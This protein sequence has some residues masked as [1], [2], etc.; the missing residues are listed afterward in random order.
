MNKEYRYILDKSSKKHLCPECGKKRFVKFLDTEI[1]EYLPDVYGRCDKGDG[2]YFL[3]P[4]TDGYAKNIQEQKNGIQTDWKPQRPTI[5]RRPKLITVFIPVEVLKQTLSGYDKN[6]FIQNLL[7][8]VPFPFQVQDIESVISLY[9]LGTIKNSYRSGAVTFPFIDI[10]NNI[11]TIQV[12]QFDKTNHTTGTDFL[13]SIIEKHH[14]RKSKPLPQW[15]TAY[16]NNEIKVSCLFGEHFLKQYQ[17]AKVFLFEAPKTAIYGTLYFGFPETSNIVCLAVYNLSSLNLEK[18]KALKG[19]NVYL[20]PDLSQDGKAFNLWSNKAQEIQEQLEG[21]RFTVSDLLEQLAPE[22]DKDQGKD[23]ADYLIKLDWQ[24]FRKLKEYPKPE[25]VE[26]F[27]AP[28]PDKQEEQELIKT[29]EDDRIK[30]L[31]NRVADLRKKI[32]GV[33]MECKSL[34]STFIQA[35]ERCKVKWYCPEYIKEPPT[36]NKLRELIYWTS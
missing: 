22:E 6:T 27:E 1:G 23:I 34:E 29:Q 32:A 36:A 20:F 4:Y 2:H 35:S 31:R 24:Q 19:R 7:L 16:N 33:E 26:K 5:K 17:S 8:N 14:I 3:D 11:R 12:K 30:K 18:C 9:R 10:E 13:H 15:L 28:Q 21:A 25:P